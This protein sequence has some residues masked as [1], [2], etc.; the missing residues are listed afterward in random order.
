MT[1]RAS[2]VV[3]TRG[4]AHRLPVLLAALERQRGADFEVVPVVDGDVDGS[5]AVIAAWSGRGVL[6]LRPVVLPEN[7]GRAG[8]LN[9]GLRHAAGDVLIRCDDDL[10]PGPDFVA[11]HVRRHDAAPGPVGVVGPCRNVL[12]DTA[13][14]RSYGNAAARRSLAAVR[15]TPPEDAWR[16]W[17]GNVSVSAGTARALGGYDE[18]YRGYGWEDVDYG[19]RLHQAGIPVLVAP[20]LI[21]DHLMGATTTLL[22]A[23]RALH[24]GAA[25]RRFG[26]F[27]G[28]AAAAAPSERSAWR[29][30]VGL[31]AK[32]VTEQTLRLVCPAVDAVSDHLPP[33]VAEKTVALLVEAA[34][35]AGTRHP[36][37]AGAAF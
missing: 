6:T 29:V 36:R 3:P 19:F 9:A 22:R 8:A 24:A 4:G 18:R 31:T 5:E 15:Q 1:P 34:D 20:E 17:G 33:W 2:V 26:E 23:R 28:S 21:V 7:A 12:P 30:L 32:L 10:D 16:L 35:A 37:R 27:H 11:G 13:F 25:R 14:A